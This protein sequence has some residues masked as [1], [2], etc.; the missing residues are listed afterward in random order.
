MGVPAV[1][2]GFVSVTPGAGRAKETPAVG[3]SVL[4]EQVK[5]VG[6]TGVANMLC[7]LQQVLEFLCEDKGTAS[8]KSLF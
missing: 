7:N 8:S 2:R 5:F 1:L 4:L 6:E 3:Q